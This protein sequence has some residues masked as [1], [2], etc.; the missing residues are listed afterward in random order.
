[1]R[2]M[3][4]R[5]KESTFGRSISRRRTLSIDAPF[6]TLPDQKTRGKSYGKIDPVNSRIE[7]IRFPTPTVGFMSGLRSRNSASWSLWT[8]HRRLLCLSTTDWR[9]QPPNAPRGCSSTL[10]TGSARTYRSRRTS[11]FFGILSLRT[12]GLVNPG[13]HGVAPR[14]TV[15]RGNSF[16]PASVAS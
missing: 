5:S 2:S 13:K 3:T 9:T 16:S 12:A 11:R 10:P 1:M 4:A 15:P 7:S 14:R 8:V 6:N